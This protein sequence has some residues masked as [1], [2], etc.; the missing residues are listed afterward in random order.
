MIGEKLVSIMLDAGKNSIPASE[1]TDL[2]YGRVVA[3]N[4][5]KIQVANEP[6]L[7]LTETFLILSALCKEKKVTLSIADTPTEV[8]LWS[9]LQVGDTVIMLRVLQGSKFL[10]L[11]KEE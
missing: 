3:V 1:K 8:V 4:P 2:L 10:V 11:Q 7:Q 6:R 9:G 5:L